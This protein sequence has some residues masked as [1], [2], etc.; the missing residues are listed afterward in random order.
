MSN[1]KDNKTILTTLIDRVQ[2]AGKNLPTKLPSNARHASIAAIIRWHPRETT[3]RK[4]TSLTVDELL[5]ESWTETGELQLLFIQ[6]ALQKGD[7]YSGQIG[8]PGGKSDPEDIDHLHT[9]VRECNEEL[10]LNLNSNT[11]LFLGSLPPREIINEKTNN[12]NL[13]HSMIFLQ[14]SQETPKMKPSMQEGS[15]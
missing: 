9:A 11:F 12:T 13:V 14:M 8:F 2:S 4:S 7:P 6:R 3:S 5:K 10:G 15:Q 1:H